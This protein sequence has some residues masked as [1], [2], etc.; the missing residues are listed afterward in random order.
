MSKE[1][2]AAQTFII[3]HKV[4]KEVW[5][6]R[7]GKSSWKKPNHAKAAWANSSHSSTPDIGK[8]NYGNRWY[9]YPKFNEQDIYEVVEIKAENDKLQKACELL[10]E[11]LD[12][13]ITSN[14]CMVEEIENFLKENYDE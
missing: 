2:K 13:V 12:Y 14:S 1:I 8:G 11:T 4:T 5:T 6:A 7:S 10:K 3:R 9:T